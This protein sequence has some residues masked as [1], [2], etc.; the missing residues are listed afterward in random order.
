MTL[1]PC[2]F[3][4]TDSYGDPIVSRVQIPLILSYGITIHKSQGMTLEKVR[5]VVGSE[6][7]PGQ[8]YTAMSRV[9]CARDIGLEVKPGTD[10]VSCLKVDNSVIRWLRG[11][12]WNI[13][14]R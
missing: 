7:Q 8:L 4:F 5:V 2:A 14:G 12:K 6:M 1:K 13:L 11:I 10:W 3:S 9:R